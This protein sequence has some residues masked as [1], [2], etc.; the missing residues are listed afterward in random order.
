[1]SKNL[2][3]FL[4]LVGG[5]I[6]IAQKEMKKRLKPAQTTQKKVESKEENETQASTENEIVQETKV[7][8][9]F[10]PGLYVCP[11][12]ISITPYG[13]DSTPRNDAVFYKPQNPMKLITSN[14]GR[15]GITC[16]YDSGFGG[17]Y[18][19]Y[20]MI[21]ETQCRK[22][23]NGFGFQCTDS[24]QDM[25]TYSCWEMR[26][27]SS[28]KPFLRFKVSTPGG[29]DISQSKGWEYIVPKGYLSSVTVNRRR[30]ME[31]AYSIEISGE[32]IL[33][34]QV[35]KF[36]QCQNEGEGVRCL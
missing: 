21:K 16:K 14:V 26:T 6:Y 36:K 24:N 5:V 22:I 17:V 31:C 7:R 10:E 23:S 27:S 3:I 28:E 25:K 13:L 19:L 11:Q 18:Y 33:K 30:E 35:T 8:K 20:Q 4:L 29:E 32:Y 12:Q 2:F 1:M 15:D 9:S 34:N